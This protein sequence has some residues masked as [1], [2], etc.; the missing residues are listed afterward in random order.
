MKFTLPFITA[1][2]GIA[3]AAEHEHEHHQ[4]GKRDATTVVVTHVVTVGADAVPLSDASAFVQQSSST[5][6]PSSSFVTLT[7]LTPSYVSSA[8]AVSSDAVSSDTV[9]SSPSSVDAASL[10]SSTSTSSAASAS[11]SSTDS[12]SDARAKGITYSPY[13]D[14]GTCK[15]A[16]DVA[17]DI[18]LLTE[19]DIIRLYDTDCDCIKNVLDAKTSSQKLFLGIYYLDKIDASVQIISE[20]ISDWSDVYTVSVGNELVNNGEATTDQIKTAVDSARSAL[21]NIGYTGTVVSVDTLVAV[22]NN[23]VLCEYSD[24]IAVNSHPFW[25]GNVSPEN[26][27]TWLQTQIS[28][29]K[30]ICGG[31]K[32]VL[33]TETGWPTQGSAYQSCVPSKANQELALQSIA[34]TVADQVLLFTTFN[35]LW[36]DPGSYGVEQY[37][38]IFD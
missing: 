17:S 37:W 3:A 6:V 33:I 34:D 36:K 16:S 14:S 30:S 28:N 32:D 38:G 20:S 9:I 15:S 1:L 13:T 21:T 29:I 10:S 22:Q 11:A 2:V 27:G 26:S 18:A 5:Y 4:H 12:A 23:P 25:D 24:F 8:D 35:D 7:T 31:V 19:F